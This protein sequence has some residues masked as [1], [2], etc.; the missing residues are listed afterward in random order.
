MGANEGGELTASEGPGRIPAIE[1]GRIFLEI[2]ATA[3][4][5]LGPCLA[6][7]ERELVEKRRVLT[8]QDIAEASAATRLLPGSTLI[9]VVS[10]LGYRLG[11]WTGSALATAACVLPPVMA[12]L[13]LAIF[14]DHVSTLSAFGPASQGLAAAVVG[15]L[16]AATYRIGR[17]TLGDPLTLLIA[18]SAFGAAAGLGLP[19]VA[20]VVAAGLIGV[21]LLSAPRMDQGSGSGRGGT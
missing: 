12:M 15:I 4:G 14:Y 13:L 17:A 1:L 8:A 21:I 7:I 3:F 2:G 16:L 9:Q 11:G 18:L 6:I 5:G 20:V 10:F 19:A